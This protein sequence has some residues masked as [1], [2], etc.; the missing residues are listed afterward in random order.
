MEIIVPHSPEHLLTLIE[1]GDLEHNPLDTVYRQYVAQFNKRFKT[2]L[3]YTH[4]SHNK[5]IATISRADFK[6]LWRSTN[7]NKL[8]H[9]LGR[10]PKNPEDFTLPETEILLDLWCSAPPQ[11]QPSD[12]EGYKCWVAMST[13]EVLV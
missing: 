4:N 1:E 12:L 7:A 10:M 8:K 5:I 2:K 13:V 6:Q 11:Q 9:L 3:V